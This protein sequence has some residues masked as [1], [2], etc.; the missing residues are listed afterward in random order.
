M[1][2]SREKESALEREASPLDT[3]SEQKTLNYA[4]QSSNTKK[5]IIIGAAILAATAAALA[6]TK[7]YLEYKAFN[8]NVGPS[9]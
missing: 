8:V 4:R 5:Y 2:T 6:A 9:F 3:S 1:E 7:F